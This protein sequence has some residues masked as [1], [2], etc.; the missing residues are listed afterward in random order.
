MK[1]VLRVLAL[2][3]ISLAACHGDTNDNDM[4]AGTDVGVAT[5]G[6]DV[7]ARLTAEASTDSGE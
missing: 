6:A 4:D 3:S 7:P 5:P 2:S 1:V